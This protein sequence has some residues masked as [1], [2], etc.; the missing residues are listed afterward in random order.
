MSKPTKKKAKKKEKI[1]LPKRLIYVKSSDKDF[2]EKWNASRDPLDFPASF[3]MCLTGKPGCSKT[4]F[5]KNIVMRIQSSSKPFERIIVMHQD[6][7]A[8]EY[9]DLDPIVISELPENDFWM[10]YNDEDEETEDGEEEEEEQ[11]P[12]TLCIIDDICFRDMDKNQSI[13]LDRLCG[14]ISTHC[15]VS[16]MCINQDVFAI[17]PIIRKCCNIWVIWKPSCVDE[18]K[19]ISRRCGLKSKDLETIFNKYATNFMDSITI[20]QTLKS[21]Y[22]IRLNGYTLIQL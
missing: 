4:M 1:K 21:P 17:D 11:R 15:N 9:K 20:D 6:R 10:N 5:C 2:I 19:I 13:L 8:K 12:K 22:P 7:K 14:F 18:L 16:L 3:R